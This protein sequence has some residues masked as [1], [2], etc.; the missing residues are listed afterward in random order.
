MV[1]FE[2]KFDF[3]IVNRILGQVKDKLPL[4]TENKSLNRKIYSV[5]V[6]VVENI[7]KHYNVDTKDIPISFLP[8][9]KLEAQN[10][11]VIIYSKNLVY[12]EQAQRLTQKIEFINNLSKEEITEF[13]LK[14]I[15]EGEISEKGNA[16][17]GLIEM[18]KKSSNPL[19]YSFEP[20]NEIVSIYHLQ[21]CIDL[22]N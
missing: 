10:N 9:F 15:S 2:G 12:S 19:K 7:C 4:I 22:E 5:S 14:S 16:G 6:E 20:L 13:Y 8:T 17:L 11:K 21:V 1:A 18:V 3:E